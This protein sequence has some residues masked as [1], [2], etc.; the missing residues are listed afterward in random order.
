MKPQSPPR[1]ILVLCRLY[2]GFIDGI[3][4][5]VWKPSGAPAMYKLWQALDE[6][7]HR[8]MFVLTGR[9][10]DSQPAIDRISGRNL[11]IEG[12]RHPVRVLRGEW[13]MP[14]WLGNWRTHACTLLH[15]ADIV[16]R[17]ALLQPD[18]VY[19][20]RTNVVTAALIA[21]CTRIPVVLRL[22]GVSSSETMIGE[23]GMYG[24]LQRWAF[25]SPFAAVI[26]TLDGSPG[27]QTLDKL[28]APSV[29]RHLVL[30]GVDF[31]PAAISVPDRMSTDVIFVG[32]LEPD[33]G[34]AEF[35]DAVLQAHKDS[36]GS[37]RG[38][39]VGDGSLSGALQ[40]KVEA[41]GLKHAI[42]FTGALPHDKIQRSLAQADIYVSLNRYGNLSNAN[43]EA[44][45]AG[46]C[47]VIPAADPITG[48]DADTDQL[49]P[50]N[51][52]VRVNR[53]GGSATLAAELKR[54]HETPGERRQRADATAT[55]ARQLLSA[56]PIRAAT[57]MHFIE[58]VAHSASAGG[59]W[60]KPAT[61]DGGSPA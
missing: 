55:V 60:P 7:H 38:I 21:R 2:S 46:I 25:R 47:T 10:W 34:C 53:N 39:V 8:P 19:A 29:P 43:L 42:R 1:R 13:S 61:H 30:N 26:C 35:V 15:T 54:L 45:A 4:K 36:G 27:R 37:I 22:L 59:A 3:G 56:W 12:L 6:S 9:G 52:V 40:D 50:T 57:E 32:R 17:L 41:A 20:D 14:R 31:P 48:T 11:R 33:K 24:R 16:G 58:A 5:R 51:T 28:L 49:L 18:V 44:L 23:S